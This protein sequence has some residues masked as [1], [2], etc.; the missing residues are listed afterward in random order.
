MKK[1]LFLLLTSLIFAGCS[2]DDEFVD[3]ENDIV[4]ATIKVKVSEDEVSRAFLGNVVVGPDGTKTIPH[5]FE[6]NDQILLIDDK[7]NHTFTIDNQATD[8]TMR[9]Q[10]GDPDKYPYF[11]ALF[12][13]SAAKETPLTTVNNKTPTLYFTLPTVQTTRLI[14][15]TSGISY[16]ENA[17]LAFAWQKAKTGGTAIFIPV[18][19][20]LSFYSECPT[21]TISCIDPS[22]NAGTNIAGDYTV[23]YNGDQSTNEGSI[24]WSTARG[25]WNAN[26]MLITASSNSITCHGIQVAGRHSEDNK[27]YD[28]F[29]AIKPGTY[30]QNGFKISNTKN[31]TSPF[32]NKGGDAKFVPSTTYYLG[33]V[34]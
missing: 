2:S 1:I 31:S 32:R 7:G 14:S 17:G 33:C 30:V 8:P 11:C 10:W 3:T 21:C 20:Y 22:T 24:S 6:P 25:I 18:V 13:L 29:I 5:Q 26:H 4:P 34:D 12:P 23:T 9:G 27:Y 15:A 19:A 28:Y 16:Q